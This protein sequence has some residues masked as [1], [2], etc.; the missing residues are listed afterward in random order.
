MTVSAL[1]QY[2]ALRRVEFDC[3]FRVGVSGTLHPDPMTSVHAPEVYHSPEHDVE[4]MSE[5]WETF[6]DGYTGQHSYSGPVMHQSE[7]LGGRL[8]DD[9]LTTPGVYVVTA[10]EVLPEDALEGEDPD[11][12]F[13]AGWIVL[14]MR[15][16][17]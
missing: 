2:K 9:I 7:F 14:K 6:S 16:E 11:D 13:P 10:V 1:D 15:E 12:P 17:A 5:E 3:P 8:A 4:V